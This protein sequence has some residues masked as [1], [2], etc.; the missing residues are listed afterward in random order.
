MFWKKISDPVCGMKVDPKTAVTRSIA[1]KTY[2]FCSEDC[3]K[4]YESQQNGMSGLSKGDMSGHQGHS[5]QSRN[6]DSM[7]DG[8]C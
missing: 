2:Y 3:A 7:S 6:Q 4:S 1:G 8:C 5:A